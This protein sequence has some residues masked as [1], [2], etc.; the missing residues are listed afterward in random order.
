M[1]FRVALFRDR[2]RIMV[3]PTRLDYAYLGDDRR[4][5]FSWLDDH[6]AFMSLLPMHDIPTV[7]IDRLTGDMGSAR[8]R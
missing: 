2:D 3:R 5:T 8:A 6:C 1:D 4:R 7:D